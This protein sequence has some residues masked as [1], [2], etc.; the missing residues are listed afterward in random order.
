MTTAKI[1][2][3]LNNSISLWKLLLNQ[4][5]SV[6]ESDNNEE[7]NARYEQEYQMVKNINNFRMYLN[8]CLKTEE[9]QPI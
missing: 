1:D 9:S 4:P 3:D 8:Y 2:P 6:E 5:V 7:N